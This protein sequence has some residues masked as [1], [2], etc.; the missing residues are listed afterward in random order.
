MPTD[1]DRRTTGDTDTNGGS[2]LRPATG[3]TGTNG[4][5]R[6]ATAPH[7]DSRRLPRGPYRD[8]INA[9]G[10]GSSYHGGHG[11]ERRIRAP[12]CHGGHGHERGSTVGNGTTFG[13]TPPPAR[14]LPRRHKCQRIRI[15]VPRGTR[16]RTEDPGSVLPRGAR[17]RTG[18]HGRQRHHI[19]IHA[20]SRAG[21]T[22]TS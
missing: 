18:V 1:P 5:P 4:G 11:H 13:F 10:S 12:S 22:A 21:L 8:V 9:N 16:T 17:A 2:G 20:A 7:S 14:A 15:V 3:D 19:R 6:S